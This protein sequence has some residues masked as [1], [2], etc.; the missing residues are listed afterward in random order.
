MNALAKKLAARIDRDGPLSV[1][2]FMTACLL[3]P[4]H[5]YYTTRDPFG[6]PGDFITAPEVSQ[7]FGELIGLWLWSV[8]QAS[9]APG[10]THLVELGP[11]RG[12][13]MADALRA[14]E[15]ATR[16]DTPFRLHLVEA[17][18]TLR[19]HQRQTLGRRTITWHDDLET[20]PR[21]G[22]L[23]FVANE[24]FDALPIRQYV[25]TTQGWRERLVMCRDGTFEATLDSEPS[26]I[27]LPQAPIG[28][29]GETAPVRL[30]VI[31]DMADRIARQGGAALI[32]DFTEKALPLVDT[33]QAV[34]AHRYADRFR[35]P[36]QADLASAVDF[37][38]LAMAAG[39][40]G[41]TTHGPVSQGTL[42]AALG[43]K[44]RCEALK[45]N[46]TSEQAMTLGAAMDRLVS[47]QGMGED[48]V[49]L[50]LLPAGLPAPAGFEVFAP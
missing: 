50:A 1:E 8:W 46:A 39:K 25:S 35:D 37:P 19:G 40:H 15:G 47:P 14:L 27:D 3:D 31:A 29:V 49:A 4:E 41:V 36:G 9:G 30:S 44:A 38:A 6:A 34:R 26:V 13:L 33:F 24:F 5:G 42:L 11:G 28:R 16:Q 10:N 12:T 20:L 23:L 32:V 7:M 18:P 21:D 43:I 48:F 45:R 2:D 22:P 17:S